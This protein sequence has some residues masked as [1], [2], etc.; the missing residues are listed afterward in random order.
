MTRWTSEHVAQALGVDQASER[1][2]FSS[3]STD[4]RTLEPGALFI[5]LVGSRFDAHDFLSEAHARGATGAVVRR[6]TAGILR[7]ATFEVEDTTVALGLLARDR[8][9]DV[10]GP[11]VAVTGTNGKTATKEMLARALGSRWRVHATKGNLN[12][13]IGV[14]LTILAAPEDTAALVVEVGANQP[15]EIA[16]L[17]E[18][19]EPTV[20]VVTNVSVGHVE[21]FGSVEQALAEKVSLLDNVPLAVVG[22]EP[23]TLP[24]HARMRAERV[25]VAGSDASAE[26]RPDSWQL[27]DDGTVEFTFQEI[28]VHLPLVGK[29]QLDNALLA[30]A[31]AV[32]LDVDPREVGA[33]LRDVE[34]P[35]GRC[36][37]LTHGDLVVLHDAYNANPGSLTAALE[38]AQ[39]MRGDRPLVV[40]VGSMLELG[41]E[42]AALH[43]AMADHV[44]AVNP[45]LIAATGAFI[46][47]FDRHRALLGNRLLTAHDPATLGKVVATRLEGHEF[48]LLKASRGVRLERAL[49]S[50]LPDGDSTCSTT[51]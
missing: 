50:L 33:A 14:P 25:V 4:T 17:G 49:T 26:V 12:N 1:R 51:S 32:E 18:V 27:H 8:R 34:L 44:M 7:L 24:E 3:I 29:H 19:I 41:R 16:Q 2:V 40:V 13:V 28:S 15:G 5:A 9:R 39:A 38:T 47:A 45:N 46:G 37:V 21:G 48:I 31:T 43:E 22:T 11:V 10:P 42:S 6:G 36:E 23:K 20:G 30:L 35:P